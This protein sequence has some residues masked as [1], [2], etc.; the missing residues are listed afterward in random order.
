[1]LAGFTPLPFKVI[2]IAAGPTKMPLYI[3]I[4]ASIIS[5]PAR[6]FLEAALLWKFG[7]PMKRVIDRNF[8]LITTVVGM[9]GVGGLVAVRYRSA[10]GRVGKVWVRRVRTRWTR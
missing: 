7:A 3:L 4:V 1:M 9:L 6:F 5:R 10:E 2:T 8:G